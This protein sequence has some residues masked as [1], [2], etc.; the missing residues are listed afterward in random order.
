MPDNI[1]SIIHA[2]NLTAEILKKSLVGIDNLS[3][4]EVR[5]KILLEMQKYPELFSGG[6]Y[7]PPPS[8]IVVL[9]GDKPYNRLQYD[10]LRK[11]DYWPAKNIFKTTES[12]G[13]TYISP[14]NK[15]TGMF[16]DI[17]FTF[18]LGQNEKIKTHLRNSYFAILEIAKHA[19]P[20][21]KFSELCGL[22]FK[23]YQHKFKPTFWLTTNSDTNHALNLG[24][25]VPG[26]LE[27]EPNPGR[28]FEQI[29]DYIKTKRIY[30][31]DNEPFVI[32]QTCAITIESRVEDY[33]DPAMPSAFFHFIVCFEQGKKTILNN[34]EKIFKAVGMNYIL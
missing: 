15:K 9:F 2:R 34:F 1:Q 4:Y 31:N 13:M 30:I 29:K 25:T 10:T 7:N 12:V 23:I 14:V 24:H 17:G 26:S 20:G 27:D 21:M 16:G 19:E 32:P 6:W 5:E 33:N 18:Y 3:E 8:G 28:D 22:A 11:K